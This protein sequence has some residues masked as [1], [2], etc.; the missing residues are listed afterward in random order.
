MTPALK[1]QTMPIQTEMLPVVAVCREAEEL[2]KLVE[3][4]NR[5]LEREK[6]ALWNPGT[7]TLEEIHRQTRPHWMW[8]DY[9]I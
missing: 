8:D 2:Q 1:G 5:A 9:A 4:G 6:W 3:E 7:L